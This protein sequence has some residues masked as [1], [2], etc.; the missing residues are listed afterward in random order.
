[1]RP[2]PRSHLLASLVALLLAGRAWADQPGPPC[3][4]TRSWKANESPVFCD[5]D[6][7]WAKDPS[8]I[9]V[10]D[11]YYMYYTSAN[12]WQGDGCGGKGDPRI[13]YATSRDGLNWTYK[14]L[15]ISKGKPGEWDEER[16]QAPA[17]PMLKDG[18]YYMYYAGKSPSSAVA[19]GYATS[20]D[21]CQWTKHPG[22]VVN[23][24]K[25]NDPFIFLENG[26]YYMFYTAGGDDVFYVTS[27]NLLDWSKKPIFTGAVGEGSIV[28]KDGPTYTILACVGWSHNGEYYK[29]YTS[30][31]LAAKFTDR[32]RIKINT[33]KFAAGTLSH[34]DVI[35]RDGEHWFYFQG[36]RDF[37]KRFQIGLAKQTVPT[38]EAKPEQGITGKIVQLSGNFMPGPDS[39][40]GRK[41]AKKPLS[42]PVH[43]FKGKVKVFDKPDMDHLAFVQKTHS[44]V[45]GVFCCVLPPGE[46]TVVAEIEGKLRLNSFTPGDKGSLYWSTVTVKEGQW[47]AVNI[48]DN[49]KAV[50]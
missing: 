7:D 36:T 43:I 38:A 30:Q 14:G 45:H 18:K 48:E 31:D 37:G 8:V 32:G 24:G 19:I 47:L 9:K 13:D 50:Y 29:A 3:A 23:Q 28:L 12:P 11:T 44:D 27:T 22:S 25:C 34:G 6:D 21:L 42:V 41:N 17:K 33:P 15:S 40:P 39:K 26:V 10:G 46:Y 1:M 49:S 35:C 4:G 5:P 20:I 2:I 16:P